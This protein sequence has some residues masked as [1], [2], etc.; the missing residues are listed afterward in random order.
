[1]IIGGIRPGKKHRIRTKLQ[2]NRGLCKQAFTITVLI[3]AAIIFSSVVHVHA[4]LL[5]VLLLIG[6]I[7]VSVYLSA[8]L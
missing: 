6:G 7:E 2:L 1:M 8:I 5:R 3:L 4:S